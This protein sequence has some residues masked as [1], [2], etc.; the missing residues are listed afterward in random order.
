MTVVSNDPIWWPIISWHMSFSHWTCSPFA[1]AAVVVYDLSEQNKCSTIAHIFMVM[2]I[3]VL[4]LGEEVELIWIRYIGILY[5]VNYATG[6]AYR[7]NVHYHVQY[8]NLDKCG[9]IYHVGQI[10]HRGL[11]PSADE[12]SRALFYKMSSYIGSQI[13]YGTLS[14]LVDLQIFVLG[15]RLILSVR[16]YHAKLVVNSD[17]KTSMNSIVFQERVH[18]STSSTV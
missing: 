11:F 12:I 15:P 18:I 14:I 8:C 5:N 13:F 16:E 1:A 2:I 9:R 10:D 7:C 4:T 3:P 17:A 6:I